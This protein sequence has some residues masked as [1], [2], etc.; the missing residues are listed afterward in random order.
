MEKHEKLIDER[1]EEIVGKIEKVLSELNLPS[2]I[3]IDQIRFAT[4]EKKQCKW[5][6]R[7]IK[8]N[9]KIRYYY[10]RVCK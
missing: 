10:K 5:V 4:S 3:E 1:R 8:R 9:G 2:D 7:R 6:R